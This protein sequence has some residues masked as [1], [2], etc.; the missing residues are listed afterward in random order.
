MQK[1]LKILLVGLGG[2]GCEI[3]KNLVMSGFTNFTLLDRDT[4]ELSNLSRQFF[5]NRKDLN[6][7]KAL[8]K[9]KLY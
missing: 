9:I 1:N 2:T 5:Y 8:V 6:K 3:L 4:V 7:S